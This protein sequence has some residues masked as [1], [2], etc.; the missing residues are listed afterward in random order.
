[1]S[2]VATPPLH[3]TEEQSAGAAALVDRVS[4]ALPLASV[5]VVLCSVY[6]FEAWKR[7]TPWLFTDELELTQLSRSIAATGRAA[8]RGQ[9]HSPDSIYTYLIAPLWLIHEVGTAYAGIKYLDVFVMAS[10]VFPTYFLAR[11]LVGR[12]AALFAAAGA[13]AI[14]SVAYS[15]YIVEET[16]A[17]P[18]AALCLFLIVKALVV[19]RR[20]WTAA[21]VLATL[22]GAAVRGELVMLPV[23]LVFALMFVAWSSDRARARRRSWS[24][25]DW[26]GA[27]TL[28]FG[29]IFLVSGIAS[30]HVWEW[31]VVTRAYKHRLIVEGNWAAGSLAIGI[32][33]IPLV[34]G[35]ASLVRAPGEEPDRALRMFRCAALGGLVAFGLYTAIKAA[36]LSTVFATRVEERNLI[37]VAP[38]LFVGTAVVLERRRVNLAALVAAA[39]YVAYLAG[40]AVYHAVGSPYEMGVRLYSDALGFAIAQQANLQLFWTPST[41]RLVLVLV[42]AG[43]LAAL[44]APRFLRD[45]TGLAGA[46]SAALAVAIVAWNLTGEIAAAAGTNQYASREVPALGRPFSWVDDVTG[47]RPTLYL[48]QGVSDQTS[49]WLLE[50]WNRSITGVSSLDGTIKGPGPAGGPNI[51]ADG[52]VYWSGAPTDLG[53]QYDYAV[54]DYPCV[55]FAGTEVADHVYRTGD[56]VK[57]W[58]LIRLTQP[59][60]LLAECTGISPDGWTGPG[61]SNYFRFGG[62]RGG[63]LRV[64]VSRR[65]WG[66]PT[67]PSPY[68]VLV[69]PLQINSNQEPQLIH[70]TAERNGS[71]ASTKT[72]V[73]WLRAPADR[74]AAR[75]VVDSKFVPCQVEPQVSSDC[76]ALGAEVSYRFFARRP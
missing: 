24:L 7:V 60:R 30:H 3:R 66:G 55:D 59:N 12:K 20:G 40:Y 38:L 36:Y 71:I 70:V 34:A 65:D 49:E 22:L 17:Y 32:G 31:Q 54:E 45:R 27:L 50:F 53:L 4:A 26:I 15:S 8:R 39:A 18:Y 52:T 69:G 58:R 33:M 13:G 72:Q 29:A 48:G 68:Q 37:Y 11:L 56:T 57:S 35:L 10:V 2:D 41:V 21:A 74:F 51:T 6:A 16:V 1:V 75:V 61:E 46:I 25:G 5:Y 23:A 73:V 67:P 47:G 44:L 9:A 63:W 76:R 64:V 43:G 42:L 62:G 14:P 28:A 19:R